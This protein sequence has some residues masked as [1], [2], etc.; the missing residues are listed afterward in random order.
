MRILFVRHA[1]SLANVGNTLD[2][3]APGASLSVLGQRQAAALP[4][5]LS[6]QVVDPVTAV[7]A[8]PLV[9]TRETAQPLAEA[10][11]LPVQ[12]RDGLKEVLAGD[13]EGLGD[14]VSIGHYLDNAQAWAA[15]D[16]DTRLPG[17][18][19]GH[20]VLA[21][22]DAV[23][24]EA[25]RSGAGSVVCVSHGCVIWTWVVGRATDVP[26]GRPGPHEM[27][28]TAFIAVDGDL[29]QGWRVTA[30]EFAGQLV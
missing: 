21:R 19:T 17:G 18:E 22:F 16:L 1:Q 3:A 15:G 11:G 24:E 6:T 26:A 5:I 4:S 12:V 27:G 2:T 8:S 9:R 23:V 25:V 13:F 28:N 29:E 20:E 7:Y 30:W 14:P 10:W